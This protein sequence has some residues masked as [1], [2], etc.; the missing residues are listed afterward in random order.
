MKKSKE[1]R[2]NFRLAQKPAREGPDKGAFGASRG[3]LRSGF[4]EV[5]P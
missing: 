5:R 2:R 4:R 3:D 1:I